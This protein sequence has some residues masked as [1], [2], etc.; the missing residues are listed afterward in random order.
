MSKESKSQKTNSENQQEPNNKKVQFFNP[1]KKPVAAP[2]R[3]SS[4]APTTAEVSSLSPV[5]NEDSYF[6]TPQTYPVAFPT[7]ATTVSP[8]HESS[9]I[10]TSLNPQYVP[11]EAP[12]FVKP[13]SSSTEAPTF[14]KPTSSS[15][16]APTF[17]KPTPSSTEAPSKA[18]STSESSRFPTTSFS[19]ANV[20]LSEVPSKSPIQYSQ[21]PTLNPIANDNN[22]NTNRPSPASI[23][24]PISNNQTPDYFYQRINTALSVTGIVA[25]FALYLAG[26]RQ[27]NEERREN[28]IQRDQEAA[29]VRE[30]RLEERVRRAEDARQANEN[31]KALMV[32]LRK[33]LGQDA[34]TP[35]TQDEI[36]QIESC[37]ANNGKSTDAN[38]KNY[39]ND[40]ELELNLENI[41]GLAVSG[42]HSSLSSNEQEN[43]S[44][45]GGK[46]FFDFFTSRNYFRSEKSPTG[47]A[48]KNEQADRVKT[49]LDRRRTYDVDS[50]SDSSIT[51]G[52]GS[53]SSQKSNK[54]KKLYPL[55]QSL[56]ISPTKPDLENEEKNSEYRDERRPVE[57]K[58]LAEKVEETTALLD[59][60]IMTTSTKSDLYNNPPFHTV[61]SDENQSEKGNIG[62]DNQSFVESYAQ[63]RGSGNS[64]ESNES[65]DSTSSI[66]ALLSHFGRPIRNPLLHG[67]PPARENFDPTSVINLDGAVNN[68]SISFVD[69]KEYYPYP[70]RT[71]TKDVEETNSAHI[72]LIIP[73]NKELQTPPKTSS[74]INSLE[75]PRENYSSPETSQTGSPQKISQF[76][77]PSANSIV[78]KAV[79]SLINLQNNILGSSYQELQNSDTGSAEKGKGQG[80][81]R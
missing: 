36:E 66:N 19:P 43:V 6:P 68:E 12:T 54:I 40:I 57:E 20:F 61:D 48:P 31:N 44:E 73:A 7:S 70:G 64:Q 14:V 42:N 46:G 47:E 25:T 9:R 1:T 53:I 81:G 5:K 18:V 3:V 77:L 21:I 45:T 78:A 4:L 80:K 26:R 23:F 62:F 79:T 15:T 30:Q 22:G 50:S 8:N 10:P 59:E 34:T 58:S 13:T 27:R 39:S 55:L 37:K 67:T 75:S 76:Q 52:M 28:T 72:A 71:S 51:N 32:I 38:L 24:P 65:N 56:S 11:T 17:V 35:A 60:I 69:E 33:S 63:R 41:I 29:L 2:V 49:I 16:E 74:K